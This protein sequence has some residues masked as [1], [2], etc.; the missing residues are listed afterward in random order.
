MP[1]DWRSVVDIGLYVHVP[2]CA[3]KCGYCDFYSHVP[4]P[5]AFGPLVD[6]LLAELDAGLAREGLRVETIFVGGGTPTLLPL[7]ELERLFSRLGQ[8]AQRDRPV[9]FTVEANPASLTVEKAAVLRQAGVNRISLGAQS[10]HPEELRTLERLHRPAD[11]P[12][13]V[14]LVRQAGFEHFNLDLIFGIPGQTQASWSESLRRAVDLGPDHLACYGL[15]YEPD[16]PLRERLD[17]GMVEPLDETTE[18]ALYEQAIDFLESQGVR[19]YEISNFARPG[20]ESRHNV[21]Y[22][23]NLPYLG[24]GPSAASYLH[25]RRWKNVPDTARY[26][27]QMHLGQS[28]IIEVEELSPLERAGETAMLQL[29]LV[30]GIH[31]TDFRQATGFDPAELFAGVIARHVERNLLIADEEHIAL[32]R[33]GRL[34]ADSVIAEFL[35][36]EPLGGARPVASVPPPST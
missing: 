31:R 11:I 29:R 17:Q 15:T 2:F 23:L 14:A 16:T 26:V 21:R 32:T 1:P 6:A 5:G 4:A 10:F 20:A 13:S 33:A 35:A 30:S 24:V 3:T 28:P 12:A 36:R 8:V 27:A 25:G 22:W 34:V 9:E 18:A 7:V 19:Q